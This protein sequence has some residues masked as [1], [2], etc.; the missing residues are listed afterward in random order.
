MEKQIWGSENIII[1]GWWLIMRFEFSFCLWLLYYL[2]IVFYD[3]FY[4]N[5]TN[6]LYFRALYKHS[7]SNFPPKYSFSRWWWRQCLVNCLE[8][9]NDHRR[10]CFPE[11]RNFG[12]FQESSIVQCSKHY[13]K[14]CKLPKSRSKIDIALKL[15]FW[16]R[17]FLIILRPRFTIML[18]KN[19]PSIFDYRDFPLSL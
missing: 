14:K 3:I 5:C 13:V 10:V 16:Y 17:G 8:V 11:G 12:R 2:H 15:F 4:Q 18:V 6:F 7:A 19:I 9:K 1:R